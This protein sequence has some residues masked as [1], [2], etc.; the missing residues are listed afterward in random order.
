MDVAQADQDEER[1]RR[2]FLRGV[3]LDLGGD[4]GGGLGFVFGFGEG[5]VM[6]DH[7]WWLLGRG[8]RNVA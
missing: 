2:C 5:I 4:V 1:L 7:L 6:G 3:E 8:V